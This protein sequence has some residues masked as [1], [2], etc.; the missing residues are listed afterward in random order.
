MSGS[1]SALLFRTAVLNCL[2]HSI[3]SY[4]PLDSVA[5][6]LEKLTEIGWNDD[7]VQAVW[8]TVLP[9]LSESRSRWRGKHHVGRP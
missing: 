4:T 9:L 6:F 1:D 3:D 2:A 8:M 7:D 5:N